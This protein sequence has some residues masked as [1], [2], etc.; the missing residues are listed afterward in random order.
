MAKILIL[1]KDEA[2]LKLMKE[3]LALTGSED[4]NASVKS[5]DVHCFII[6]DPITPEEIPKG[7]TLDPM[8]HAYKALNEKVFD[9]VFIEAAQIHGAPQKWMEEFRKK[10]TLEQNKNIPVVLLSYSEDI[11]CRS[12]FIALLLLYSS[13]KRCPRRTRSMMTG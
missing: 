7:K 10:I 5:E 9:F 6:P 13:H 11:E 1:D 12:T 2:N 4:E 3:A 8:E